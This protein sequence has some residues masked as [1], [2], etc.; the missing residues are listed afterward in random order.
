VLDV[1]QR[2]KLDKLF[3]TAEIPTLPMVAR[4]LVDLCKDEDITVRE[5]V[6]LIKTDQGLASRVLRVANSAYFGMQHKASTLDRAVIALGFEYVKSISL[7][8]H[9]AH[10]LN[11][12]ASA[13]GFD[14]TKFWRENLTRGLL[15]RQLAAKYCTQFK[16]EAFLIGLLQ[17]SGILLLA[18]VLGEEYLRLY[19]DS[20]NSPLGLYR[21]ERQLFEIDHVKAISVLA[22]QWSLPEVLAQP[23]RTHHSRGCPEPCQDSQVQLSQ[24]GYFVGSFPLDDPESLC[25]E[26]LAL[27]D[28][29]HKTFTLSSV[30]LNTLLDQMREEFVGLAQMFTGILSE[31]VDIT[32]LVVQAKNLLSD[33]AQ[34]ANR[35]IFDLEQE[36]RQLCLQREDLSLSLSQYQ[37]RAETDDL[38]G[39]HRRIPLENYL[40]KACQK[41]RQR[42]TSL[43]ILFLDIDNFKTIN[44][45]HSHAAGDRVLQLL[46]K[47]LQREF[48]LSGCVSRYGG[49]EFVI[50][51]LEQEFKSCLHTAGNLLRKI[52]ELKIPVRSKNEQEKIRISCSIGLLFCESGSQPGNSIRVLELADNQ[53]REAK[54]QGKNNIRFQVIDSVKVPSTSISKM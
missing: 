14:T 26:D 40:D 15:A 1:S 47:L 31:K 11:K 17:D 39:I 16:Q 44:D 52:Q 22:E 23:I 18:Q 3:H 49:D 48:S 6:R 25:G 50:A 51:L 37:Y 7:G 27:L 32:T 30:A 4:K 28:Y 33:L 36:V 20:N 19:R 54:R 29:C 8:F 5:L 45:S 46:A 53:M 35:K 24:I 12:L 21:L 42:K 9:L 10:T 43:A 2:E 34:D 13:A 41:V 38:T